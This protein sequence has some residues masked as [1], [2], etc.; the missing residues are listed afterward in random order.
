MHTFADWRGINL[1][2]SQ[3]GARIHSGSCSYALFHDRAPACACRAA[4]LPEHAWQ[5]CRLSGVAN[6]A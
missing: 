4:A 5:P 2:C 3:Q 1:A 6:F